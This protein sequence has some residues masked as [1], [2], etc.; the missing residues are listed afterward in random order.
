MRQLPLG[1]GTDLRGVEARVATSLT[2]AANSV[3]RSG[4]ELSSRS[5]RPPDTTSP[6]PTFDSLK[7]GHTRSTEFGGGVRSL[8]LPLSPADVFG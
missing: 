7:A 1:L 6:D 4:G 5:S 2:R 8:T 3:G